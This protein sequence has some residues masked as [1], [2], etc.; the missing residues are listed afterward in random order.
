MASRKI[1]DKAGNIVDAA[2]LSTSMANKAL[3]QAAKIPLALQGPLKYVPIIG[4]SF[5]VAT[6]V[7]VGD[8]PLEQALASQIAA[9]LIAGAAA[10]TVAG[11]GVAILSGPICVGIVFIAAGY[12]TDNIVDYLFQQRMLGYNGGI[13]PNDSTRST[14]SNIRNLL[15]TA[16]TIPSP[17][18]LD[19]NGDGVTTTA[20][21]SG[22]YFDHAGDGF[23]EQTAWVSAEDG[24]LVRDLNH[25]GT[26]DTGAELFGNNTVLAN[27]Q[28]AANGFLALA[29]LD[30]NKDGKIDSLDAAFS[31]LQIWKDSDGDGITSTGE[32]HS[33]AGLGIAS[34]S[35]A[36][37]ASSTVDANGSSHSQTGTYTTT[38]G[39][40]R[41][42]TDVWF[43]TDS[44][45]SFATELL[46]V[47]EDIF[48]LPEIS[49]YGHVRSLQQAM[50][51]KS[52]LK[53]LVVQFAATINATD[54]QT[55][56]TQIIYSWAGVENVDPASRTNSY[57]GN[58]I[59]DAR[60]LEALE[61]F[62]GEEWYGIWCW[63]TKDPNPHGPAA[64]T[65]LNAYDMLFEMVYDQLMLQTHLKSMVDS[66]TY[67]WDEASSSIHGD[68]S[69]T[70]QLV[71]EQITQNR[72]AG[73]ELLAEF[74]RCF[75]FD[76][77]AYDK[78]A[79]LELLTPLGLDVT[80]IVNSALSIN[81][82]SGNDTLAGTGAGDIMQGFSGN[83][84]LT[85][86]AGDDWLEGGAGNDTLYGNAGNDKLFG[87]TGADQ[88]FGNEG[89]D[90]YSF[91]KGDGQDVFHDDYQ[92]DSIISLSGLTLESLVFQRS[93]ADLIVT[94]TDNATDSIKLADFFKNGEPATNLIITTETGA[95]VTFDAASLIQLSLY[96]TENADVLD[97]S[98]TVD[99]ISALG[100][101]DLVYGRAGNDILDGGSGND[102]ISGNDGDDQLSGGLANDFLYG[103]AGIDT[104]NGGDG[105]DKLFGDDGNDTLFGNTGNDTLDGG[106]GVDTLT[107]GTGDDLYYLDNAADVV[108][109]NAGEGTDTVYAT[110]TFTMAANIENATLLGSSDID[111]TGNS[112]INTLLGNSGAN[113]LYGLSG[114]DTLKG[115]DGND[116]L[117]G[118]D[119][120][121]YLYGGLGADS[122]L[123]GLGNDKLY[124]EDGADTLSGNDGDDLLDGGSGNDILLG[125][126]GN[127]FLDGNLGADSLSGGSGDDS[128]IIDD[129]G[130]T[131]TELAGEGT[132]NANSSVSFTLAANVE[133]LLL[134]GSTAID[135][136]GNSAGN[137]LLGN[138]GANHL[139]GLD[140]NDELRGNAGDDVLD[141]G[142]GNDVLDGGQ[143]KDTLLGGL[144]DDTYYVDRSDDVVTENLDEG[145]DTVRSTASYTISANVED[146]ILESAAGYGTATGN[147]LANTL[148]GNEYG[149]TLSGAEGNDTLSGMAG[150]DTLLGGS[151]ADTLFGGDG[152]DRLDGGTEADSM[153]GGLGNDI[154]VVDTMADVVAE[155]ASV[156]TDT[157]ESS[158]SYV[159][160]SKLE[161]L[162][163]TGSSAINATGN[164]LDNVILGNDAENS[165]DGGTGG[166]TLYGGGGNDTYYTDNAADAIVEYFNAGTDT[167][168]RDFETSAILAQY[169]DNLTLGSSILQGTGNDLDN[170]ITGNALN[171]TLIGSSGNDTL[172]GGAGDDTYYVDSVNDQI[173][174]QV[175]DGFDVVNASS[176][177]TLSA[178]IENLT[179]TE[180][181]WTATAAGNALAN[182]IHG[183]SYNN[184]LLGND[185]AD[186]LYGGAGND[187]LDGGTG[188][189]ILDGGT[190]D[191]T[192]VVDTSS[193][194]IIEPEGAG[195]DTVEASFS[196]TLCA[197]LENL[198]LTGTAN[199]DATGN[200]LANT[201]KGNSG[202]NRIDGGAG[203]DWMAGGA[204]NDTYITETSGDW[205]VENAGEGIDL[206]FRNYETTL[207]LNAN[208]EN[209][210]LGGT[211][212]RGNGNGLD[213][214]ITGNDSDNNL[215]GLAGND[216]LIG[217]AGND[218]LFGSLGQ[219]TLI[220][221]TG[222]DYYEIDNAADVITE[223]VGE[224]DDF[225]RATISWTLGANLERLAVDGT[226]AL[227]VTGNTLANGLWGNQGDN[228]MIGGLGN[229]YLYGDK[230]QDTYVFNLGDGQ[231]SIDD[232]DL[233][234]GGDILQFG[235]S[236]AENDVSAFQYGTSLFF[237]IKNSTDQ[238]GFI[239]Y[240]AAGTVVDGQSYDHKINQIRFYDGITWD[241][242]MI[243]TVVDRANNNQSPTV[244]SY[245]PT[246]Q[247]KAGTPF[248]YVVPVSTITDPDPWDS[249]TYSAK[250]ADGSALPS[251]L[252]FDAA[253]RTFS[254][255][256]T[257]SGSLQFILWGTDNYGYSA[258]EYV[259]MTIGA[260]NRAPVVST[261][262]ADQTAA[263]GA[264]FSYTVPATAFTD[265]DSDAL[266]YSAI[267][268]D[269]TALPSWLTFNAS[270][271]VFSGTPPTGSTGTVSVKVTAKDTGNLSVF[272]VFNITVSVQNLT[273]NGTTGAD[274][275]TGGAGNDTLNG[276]AGNDT[277]IGNAGND[278]L[279]GGT[280]NDAMKG[281]LGNDIYVVD[282]T[283]DVITE[284]LNE[285][286]DLVQSSVTYTLVA[287]VEN[288]TLTGTSAIS[289]TG[290]ALD[291]VLTGNSA[292][293]TL[294]GGDGN[295]AIDG[296]AGSDTM[297][298][299][300]GDDTYY[301]NV[302]TDKITEAASAGTD[303]VNS[304]VTLTLASNV[305]NLL[306]TGTSAI[307]G[308]GNTLTNYLR[309]NSANNTLNGGS[310]N[311][312]LEGGTGTDTLTDTSG[313]AY[314]NGGAGAD[315]MTGGTGAE[316]FI[317]GTGNDTI[318][319]STGTD[320][321]AF[322]RGDGMDTVN[323]GTGTDNTV[324]LG[325]GIRYADLN[326][327]KS[328]NDLVL[329]VGSS[330]SLIFKNWYVTTAN[331]K[332][333]A[334]LQV[335]LDA[336]S[337][338]NA[339]STDQTLN[340]KV[341]QFD[342]AGLVSKF[343]AAR[344]ANTSL[345]SWAL[346]NALS[347]HYLG[348]SDT[349]A[350]GGD[351]AYWYG[352]N[353]SL[354]GMNVASAQEVVADA[355]FGTANQTVRSFTG[356]QNG[357]VR[358]T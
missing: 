108:V 161:N 167:E 355:N 48:N 34:I 250:M 243:Q 214:I 251:W 3:E 218:A 173:I 29:D 191:D 208:V 329:D 50:V 119:G 334:K 67:V 307:N 202:N 116:T 232:Y 140:G 255:T 126:A 1:R 314:L 313:K 106:T 38:D 37:T 8:E 133:N 292:N 24:L 231:D 322:N 266:T 47:P 256:P 216:T 105:D 320:I 326:F 209:L 18:V 163:L 204:G 196:F 177:Y 57:Y 99:T 169:V 70:A 193:D 275:L 142:A 342:F 35:T 343:D 166:D 327:K 42:A 13:D 174:E 358:L 259:N 347:Q 262:L 310:G 238:I 156:G 110:A 19:L 63:G 305:E 129:S 114:D 274:T 239:D 100:G 149:N 336:T 80:S 181:A 297:V 59:G 302:S 36:Y 40:T 346:S 217:G 273:L 85:G 151:G 287:N 226:S 244:N 178:N 267:L 315:T 123:G 300:N 354:S 318:T 340:N 317:G 23:A 291:N 14:M 91:S 233:I 248:T 312:I 104:L 197:T 5:G 152:D 333:V 294:T 328:S 93:G 139:Y 324:S 234:S 254:G 168:I 247:A 176:S 103:G 90:T 131:I 102:N 83:D 84:M 188:I 21:T 253:T 286:T 170:I 49:G 88:T 16:S 228:V 153:T 122:L 299:G 356:L 43:K 304:S 357:L 237:K 352:K 295:D 264:T 335:I 164:E 128:Y 165:I 230:G 179:L 147:S 288:L 144:G 89:S 76:G 46:D 17:I 303:T 98:S 95:S 15:N 344:A 183:N 225:V 350:L 45:Y 211:I 107:G 148:T 134:V 101:D 74:M 349:A 78:A 138:S 316:L 92:Q 221:G 71:T 118:G 319:T 200:G 249:V 277:L 30:S 117:D 298:G 246:L 155:S 135:G 62:V 269:G 145:V 210:A 279:N 186:T 325:G 215:F 222:D 41:T 348:G 162:T 260:A 79:F 213:N 206:E 171:N 252:S 51:R 281:G 64:P 87:G 158:I 278:T 81:G 219:D 180:S 265:P 44:L 141:G 6:D 323:G 272:D 26:I 82:S 270:T 113:R 308:T 20:L 65:V 276:N 112:G 263:E 341:E 146:L 124:G 241:Q 220:G 96:P 56:T 69:K 75:S 22:A 2:T 283:S 205:I 198:T 296:G 345:T 172:L 311:D 194:Q 293:N 229:D 257:A 7:I 280:G 185:G 58:V 240:F 268:S 332:S 12:Y 120:Q 199:I 72:S 109:E 121:D 224:G 184:T 150:N 261:L 115:F 337:D 52:S 203:V 192:Y 11:A 9:S 282:S 207:I 68:L 137:I 245:L 321:L 289:G 258:G 338:Y 290:N 66:I 330:E 223:N 236:I 271:R 136:T 60:K 187:R 353:G 309:G 10:G 39:Q 154:Y 190:G 25:N 182:T 127:D 306:L 4:T 61:E 111:A 339:A 130:D 242:A 157:V 189:D 285:G 301:V 143:G 132:D 235:A 125:G 159:L 53:D 27:A 28:K 33:L 55:L 97:G 77:V 284:N 94:F 32:L 175:G 160:G 201:I 195:S 86:N 351:L 227:S 73:K 31:E 331:N 212:Y 54:R